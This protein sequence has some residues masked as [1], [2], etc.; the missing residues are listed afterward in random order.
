MEKKR[1]APIILYGASLR[2]QMALDYFGKERVKY[3]CDGDKRK[4]GTFVDGIEVISK[5]YL[6]E[7]KDEYE[8]VITSSKWKEII[9]EL[10]GL[11]ISG[12]KVFVVEKSV[13]S[14][15]EYYN[16]KNS[17]R[18]AFEQCFK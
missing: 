14:P 13:F 18:T 17:V 8:I 2:G 15:E 5:E 7:I 4:V 12:C 3:F 9:S 1:E 10:N 11:G 6:L 16:L